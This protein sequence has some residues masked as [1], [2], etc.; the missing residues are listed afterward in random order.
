MP[1]LS[2]IGGGPHYNYT[3][4][5]YLSEVWLKDE[6]ELW[7]HNM[8]V[9]A[10]EMAKNYRAFNQG[11]LYRIRGY[12][13]EK[14]Q[15]GLIKEVTLYPYCPDIPSESI[16][17]LLEGMHHNVWEKVICPGVKAIMEPQ[18]I[19]NWTYLDEPF[20]NKRLHFDQRKL[21]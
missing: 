7:G 1:T 20:A 12:L 2:T 9:Q 21:K 15:M 3:N 14:L 6:P 5:G 17:I 11:A 18:A 8:Y 10:I 13:Q 16:R 19:D 4:N